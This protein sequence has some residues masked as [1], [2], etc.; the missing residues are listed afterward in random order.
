MNAVQNI[1][2]PTE[3]TF[4]MVAPQASTTVK[5]ITTGFSDT[6]TKV[7][8]VASGQIS[9]RS[10]P[11][12][13]KRSSQPPQLLSQF[14]KPQFPTRLSKSDDECRHSDSL[15]SDEEDGESPSSPCQKAPKALS[16]SLS[17]L[18]V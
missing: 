8:R 11:Y 10:K 4:K 2:V 18:T 5:T 14:R 3:I 1:E 13:P 7:P 12:K 9:K 15:F 6:V 17:D 16:L